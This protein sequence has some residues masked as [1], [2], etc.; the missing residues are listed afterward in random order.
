MCTPRCKYH[1]ADTVETARQKATAAL[2]VRQLVLQE[3]QARKL[4]DPAVNDP[5]KEEKAIE[6][7]IL[8][9]IK[10]PRSG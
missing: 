5:E 4:V 2:V 6:T 1:P 9:D 7:L 10:N 8:Q 3:A